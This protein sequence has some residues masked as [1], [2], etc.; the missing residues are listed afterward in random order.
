MH[1]PTK[2]DAMANHQP[3]DFGKT[4]LEKGKNAVIQ[5]GY[6]RRSTAKKNHVTGS[7]RELLNPTS[8]TK[9]NLLI[10]SETKN[11]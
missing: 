6:R 9:E 8:I 5:K 7:V 4:L 2:Y 11:P 1:P 10:S 3:R